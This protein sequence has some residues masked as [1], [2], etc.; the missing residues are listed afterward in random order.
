MD[1]LDRLNVLINLAK[2]DGEL[3]EK[4]RRQ[5][6]AIGQAN[7]LMVAEILPLFA[8]PDSVPLNSKLTED[9]KVNLLLEVVQLMRIDEKVYKAEIKYC[10][11]VASM[12]GYREEVVFEL[13]LKAKELIPGD[14]VALRK[15]MS[16]YKEG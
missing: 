3:T 2:S 12:L 5:I 7:H 8:A 14:K 16:G 4:E 11:Q 6:L 15:V 1:T 10:A 13:L 9:Q